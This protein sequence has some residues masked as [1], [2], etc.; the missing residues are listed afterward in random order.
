[1]IITRI[2]IIV[3]IVIIA[4]SHQIELELQRNCWK[5][6]SGVTEQSQRERQSGETEERHIGGETAGK[7][8]GKTGKETERTYRRLNIER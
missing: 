1:V 5:R 7:K 6:D 3:V 8:Q 2:A 4:I